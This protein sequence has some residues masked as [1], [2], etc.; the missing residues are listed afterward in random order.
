M[1]LQKGNQDSNNSSPF[2]S[3]KI[4][5]AGMV[6]GAAVIKVVEKP[7]K[8][9]AKELYNRVSGFFK[10][11]VEPIVIPADIEQA[12]ISSFA[13]KRNDSG[14]KPKRKKIPLLGDKLF[15]QHESVLLVAPPKVGKTLLTIELSKNPEAGRIAYFLLEDYNDEVEERYDIVKEQEAGHIIVPLH[16][17]NKKMDDILTAGRMKAFGKA[18]FDTATKYNN[19]TQEIKNFERNFNRRLSAEGIKK[20]KKHARLDC[21]CQIIESLKGVADYVVIDTLHALLGNGHMTRNKI[22]P[23]ILAAKSNQMGLLIV[24]HTNKAG[25]VSG[26][27]DLQ[28]A[29]ET[30]M[31]LTEEDEK[32]DRSL[33]KLDVKSRHRLYKSKSYWLCMTEINEDVAEFSLID[34]KTANKMKKG[35]TSIDE[36]IVDIC[37]PYPKEIITVDYLLKEIRER[38]GERTSRQS[39]KNSLKR[40]EDDGFIKKADGTSWDNIEILPECK[41]ISQI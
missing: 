29:V 15:F 14:S 41:K 18:I 19:V 37:I 34:K 26:T 33:L 21:V 32:E 13:E 30:I 17:I 36:I 40:L 28:G 2:K 10:P 4:F 39:L 22:E 31:T 25:D 20:K 1:G 24:H 27:V 5:I 23:I 6:A 7:V 12:N 16:A 38:K 35:P 11:E 9:K 3:V 8:R